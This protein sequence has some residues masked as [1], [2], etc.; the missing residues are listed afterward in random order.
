MYTGAKIQARIREWSGCQQISQI[1]WKGKNMAKFAPSWERWNQISFAT[2]MKPMATINVTLYWLRT[3][4]QCENVKTKRARC[5]T[6]WHEKLA[7][8]CMWSLWKNQIVWRQINSNPIG[9]RI[10]EWT[11]AEIGACT[12]TPLFLT[13][14]QSIGVPL[15][16][17]AVLPHT[18]WTC[19]NQMW[20]WHMCVSSQGQT[21]TSTYFTAGGWVHSIVNESGADPLKTKIRGKR[22]TSVLW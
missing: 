5:D 14:E 9:G 1:S 4:N 13:T 3:T 12:H 10:L 15:A 16:F 17:A 11:L 2:K 7:A 19:Y 20:T 18:S 22:K 21:K 6:W 8:W